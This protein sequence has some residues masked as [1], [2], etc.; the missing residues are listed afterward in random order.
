MKYSFYWVGFSL[1]MAGI[2]EGDDLRKKLQTINHFEY[3]PR[4]EVEYLKYFIYIFSAG[5]NL[6]N[7][8]STFILNEL[9]IL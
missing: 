5:D 2:Y 6:P 7:K 4:A 9:S 8:F 3:K 1:Y